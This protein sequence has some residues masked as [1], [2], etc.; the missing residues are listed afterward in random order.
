MGGKKVVKPKQDASIPEKIEEVRRAIEMLDPLDCDS[1]FCRSVA[2]KV[3]ETH[4][5]LNAKRK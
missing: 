5:A 2:S 1:D 4:R 3:L